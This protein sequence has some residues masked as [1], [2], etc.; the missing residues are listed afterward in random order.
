MRR[1]WCRQWRRVAPNIDFSYWSGE[2]E[3]QK[4]RIFA[5]GR[6]GKQHAGRVGRPVA[7]VRNGEKFNERCID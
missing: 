5:L 6:E 3:R 1:Q 2:T 4:H 7:N